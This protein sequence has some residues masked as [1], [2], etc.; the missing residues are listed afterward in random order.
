MH[1]IEPRSKKKGAKAD[2]NLDN[3]IE[4]DRVLVIAD[5]LGIKPLAGDPKK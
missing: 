5:K 4:G 2:L 3:T 1:E